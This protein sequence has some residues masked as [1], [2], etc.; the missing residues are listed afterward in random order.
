MPGEFDLLTVLFSFVIAV[1]AGFVAF[2][3]IKH[4]RFTNHKRTWTL[5]SGITLGL[6]IWSMHF[7]GMLAWQPP[8]PLYYS[9]DSTLISVLAAVIASWVAL[10]ITVNH[11]EDAPQQNLILGALVVGTGICTMH[12][13]GMHALQFS[14]PV[15]WST[16][17]VMLSF[18]IAVMASAGAMALLERAGTGHFGLGRQFAAS[19]V[20]G[21]A[22]CG[23]HYT[24]MMAMSVPMSAVCLHPHDAF[25][26]PLLARIGV[27][28][29][30]VFSVALLVI[31]YR[32][33]AKQARAITPSA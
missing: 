28:N 4:T 7:I 10:H 25:S 15:R 5:A 23:M 8:Y 9:L 32:D 17:G 14:Q 12:Y 16:P 31:V 27:G 21:L 20:I 6:G 1:L 33:K 13:L 3:S 11:A 2:E 29:A 22:I 18:L 26:G 19:V 24:G 30:G